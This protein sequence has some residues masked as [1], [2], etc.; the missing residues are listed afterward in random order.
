MSV[1][2]NV[3][4]HTQIACFVLSCYIY[5]YKPVNK[6]D[7]EKLNHAPTLRTLQL[8]CLADCS[9]SKGGRMLE[10]CARLLLDSVRGSQQH[11]CKKKSEPDQAQLYKSIN[12]NIISL[13]GVQHANS[14]AP[15]HHRMSQAI[16]VRQTDLWC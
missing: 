2:C 11:S 1:V 7:I 12:N 3:T 4:P 8:P 9:D 14:V 5:V 16:L 10:I 15:Q 6:E 13:L